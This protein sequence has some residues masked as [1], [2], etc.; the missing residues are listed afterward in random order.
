MSVDAGRLTD[1]F[2][3]PG[4]CVEGCLIAIG[5]YVLLLYLIIRPPGNEVQIV[6]LQP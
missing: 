2:G 6:H 1:L 5:A 3:H 4:A